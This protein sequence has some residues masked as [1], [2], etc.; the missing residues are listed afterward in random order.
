MTAITNN[1]KKPR[2]YIIE[3][4]VNRNVEPSPRIEYYESRCGCG[5]HFDFNQ[6]E[7]AKIFT[8]IHEALDE[9]TAMFNEHSYQNQNPTPINPETKSYTLTYYSNNTTKHSVIST[10]TMKIIE[11]KD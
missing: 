10:V 6:K 4:I 2:K 5:H 7:K 11:L 3:K 8:Y 1:Y 9:L